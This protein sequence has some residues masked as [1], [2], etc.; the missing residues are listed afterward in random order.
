MLEGQPRLTCCYCISLR[1]KGLLG[2][3]Q[4]RASNP[5]LELHS[6]VSIRACRR[7]HTQSVT[8]AG[9]FDYRGGGVVCGHRRRAR[10]NQVETA[11]SQQHV[12]PFPS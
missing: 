10:R 8:Y 1:W 2:A 11:L 7:A 12:L 6:T 3:I 4:Q 5:S 9:T